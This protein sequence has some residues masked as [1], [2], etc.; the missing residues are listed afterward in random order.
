NQ[1]CCVLTK[2]IGNNSQYLFYQF[3]SMKQFIISLSTGGGQPNI[4]QDIVRF[5]TLCIPPLSEQI[6]ISKYLDDK[7]A[8]ID[9]IIDNISEQINKLTQLRKTLINDVVTGKI[10]VTED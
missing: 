3:L 8:Q 2:P 6:A 10:K 9:K 5:L 1:A 4:N 7:T